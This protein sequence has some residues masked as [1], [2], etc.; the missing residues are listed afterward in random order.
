MQNDRSINSAAMM[1]VALRI[2]NRYL[3]FPRDFFLHSRKLGNGEDQK[4]IA[5]IDLFHIPVNAALDD[6]RIQC[7][8]NVIA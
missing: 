1:I 5:Y 4:N 7:L 3:R 6:V 2:Y 8:M